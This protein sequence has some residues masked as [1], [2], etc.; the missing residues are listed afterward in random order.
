MIRNMTTFGHITRRD[1][2]ASTIIHGYIEGKRKSGIPKINWM[3]DIF[4]FFNL[5]QILDISKDRSKWRKLL[6]SLSCDPPMMATSR[7]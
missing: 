2:L 1:S 5:R 6:S 3:N 4:E 7:D